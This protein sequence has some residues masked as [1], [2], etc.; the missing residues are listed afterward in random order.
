MCFVLFSCVCLLLLYLALYASTVGVFDLGCMCVC[1]FLLVAV[2][3]H[4]NDKSDN[5]CC[6]FFL[7]PVFQLLLSYLLLR[8]ACVSLSLDIFPFPFPLLCTFAFLLLDFCGCHCQLKELHNG[9]AAMMG[10][11]GLVTH[12]LITGG[13]P[14]FEQISRGVYTGGIQ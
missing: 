14:A 8:C 10:I 4:P 5:R 12:N 2:A 6:V 9:R 1:V 13:M 3:R 7:F 11:S